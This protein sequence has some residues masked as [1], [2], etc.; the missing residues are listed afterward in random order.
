[1]A[2]GPALRH[3]AI[4]RAMELR[5]VTVDGSEVADSSLLG[6]GLYTVPE[7]AWLTG[8]AQARLRRWLR[9]YRTVPARSGQHRHRCGSASFSTSTARSVSA[10]SI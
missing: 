4:G 9:G 1:M 7:A 5:S 2:I 6:I 3:A 8:I 10:F